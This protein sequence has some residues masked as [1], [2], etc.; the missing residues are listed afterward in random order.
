MFAARGEAV[1]FFVASSPE[2]LQIA[3]ADQF[4]LDLYRSVVVDGEIDP[5]VPASLSIEA[6]NLPMSTQTGPT[7]VEVYVPKQVPPG[8]YLLNISITSANASEKS[9]ESGRAQV[10]IPFTVWSLELPDR[11]SFIPQMNCYDLPDH[12]L[13]YL[14][15]AHDHRLT[16]NQLRY[17]WSGKVDEDTIPKRTATGTWDWTEFDQKFG[18][19]FDGSAFRGLRRDGVPLEAWYLPF[20]ENCP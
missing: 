10:S 6:L 16:L 9:N 19:L 13:E 4:D 18:P 2:N 5:L 14:K 1:C 11:L 3:G 12:E 8:S 17:G 7:L 20:N 15:L